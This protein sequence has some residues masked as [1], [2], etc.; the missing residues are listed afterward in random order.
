MPPSPQAS[1]PR[2]GHTTRC[3]KNQEKGEVTIKLGEHQ[4]GA[5]RSLKWEQAFGAQVDLDLKISSATCR[6]CDPGL[7]V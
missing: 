2:D 3:H 1:R 4:T 5:E 6:L 7:G